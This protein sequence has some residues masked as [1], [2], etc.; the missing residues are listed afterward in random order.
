MSD[1]ARATS[2][3]RGRQ[4]PDER[5]Q[6]FTG[7]IFRTRAGMGLRFDDEPPPP[8]PEPVSQGGPDAGAGAQAPAGDRPRR[9]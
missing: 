4:R 2:P 8:P 9:V 3:A 7:S 1:R 5:T 6:V